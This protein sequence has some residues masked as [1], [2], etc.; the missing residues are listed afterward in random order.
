MN[1]SRIVL[2]LV[3]LALVT[4][5]ASQ[6]AATPTVGS[7]TVTDALGR[8]ITFDKVPE[9]IVIAGRAQLMATDAIYAFPGASERIIALGINNQ[10]EGHFV[11]KIDAN[12]S[13]K[14]LL[15]ND[16]GPEQIAGLNP[17]AV[18]LK[19]YLREKP[20]QALEDIGIKVIYLDLETPEQYQRDL[21]TLGKLLQNESRAAELAAF[22]Q[23]GVAEVTAALAGLKEVDK[24]RTLLLY[25]SE[26][27]GAVAFNVAPVSWIQ[28]WMVET[29]GGIPV[30]LDA[31][32]GGGWTKV[33]LE[34]VA[35]WDADAIFIISYGK[36]INQIVADL[37]AD[38]QW[39]ALRAVKD[40]KIYGFATDQFSWDQPDV[41]W[42]LGLKWL[43]GKL[44]PDKFPGL[45]I[46]AEAKSFYNTL[47]GVDEAFF[48]EKI[49]PTFKG[50]L[51]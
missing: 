18:I 27:D 32:P 4:A 15:P 48:T 5:C 44:H 28:T 33:S 42:L 3:I 45:D 26:K 2:M 39:Q 19:S 23:N 40:G 34:Q 31:N 20:G 36:K 6:P 29:A 24:P 46:I 37:K 51:P 30:W 22:F 25:Y 50:S 11:E 13:Q 14:E 38:P 1:S 17:D 10:G 41:R 35:A 21:L 8:T 49:L 9:R 16:V 47:Y 7:Y 43:A 12:Y